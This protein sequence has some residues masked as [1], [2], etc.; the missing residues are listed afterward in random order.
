MTAKEVG[1]GWLSLWKLFDPK[2]DREAYK[3]STLIKFLYGKISAD[4]IRKAIVPQHYEPSEG[5]KARDEYW[6]GV[7]EKWRK[8]G[9]GKKQ[10]TDYR[11]AYAA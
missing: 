5:E 7:L 9:K 10:K 3:D 2:T 4:E 1:T 8:S 6:P 11:L